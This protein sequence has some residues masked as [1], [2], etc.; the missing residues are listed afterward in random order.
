MLPSYQL[1]P[2][3]PMN[4][5]FPTNNISAYIN[6]TINTKKFNKTPTSKKIMAMN[7]K[8]TKTKNKN[9]RK[10]ENMFTTNERKTIST[11]TVNKQAVISKITGNGN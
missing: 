11:A 8:Q 7:W 5:N 9:E 4:P 10:V 2:T 1:F 6:A 3:K